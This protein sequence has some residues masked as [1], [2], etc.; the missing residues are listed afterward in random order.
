LRAR[1]LILWGLLAGCYAPERTECQVRC[2][3]TGTCPWGMTCSA[4]LCASV[5]QTC[6]SARAP[7]PVV[8]ACNG[9]DPPRCRS[10][11]QI[12]RCGQEGAW[13]AQAACGDSAVCSDGACVECSPGLAQCTTGEAFRSCSEA[14]TWL[15]S[16]TCPPGWPL[17]KLGACVPRCF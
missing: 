4:G 12:E 16:V 9:S 15:P 17:C 3:D 10:E 13:V 1:P 7:K 2:S 5:G 6:E 11:R 8:A 14:G